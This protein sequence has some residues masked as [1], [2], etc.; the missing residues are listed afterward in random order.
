MTKQ[1]LIRAS[2]FLAVLAIAGC[3]SLEQAA[4]PVETFAGGGNHSALQGGREIYITRCAKC[5]AVEPVTKYSAQEWQKI[6]PE[7]A[8]KAHLN[9]TDTQQVTA[10]VY[11]VLNA[12]PPRRS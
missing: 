5:H 3:V 7:M 4:P 6:M 1:P 9:L 8:E 10:Y 11:K 2:L 12:G